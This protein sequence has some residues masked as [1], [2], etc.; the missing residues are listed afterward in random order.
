MTKQEI[1]ARLEKVE[2]DRF[3]LAMKDRWDRADF[4]E[5]ARLG[6]EIEALKKEMEA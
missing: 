6:R 1:A 4:D 3:I 5:D 2:F